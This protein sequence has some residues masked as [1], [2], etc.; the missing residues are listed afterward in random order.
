MTALGI[1]V[2]VAKETE[3][4]RNFQTC[5]GPKTATPGKEQERSEEHVMSPTVRPCSS[6]T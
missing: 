6:Q 3:S 4:Q 1:A 2:H 5:K